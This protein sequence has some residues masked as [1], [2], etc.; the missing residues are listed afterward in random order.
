MCTW[1]QSN[2]AALS[3]LSSSLQCN[4]FKSTK[5]VNDYGQTHGKFILRTIEHLC[6][7]EHWALNE[8]ETEYQSTKSCLSQKCITNQR[9]MKCT[10]DETVN[11]F[12]TLWDIQAC[13][14]LS[15][16][17]F[18]S[19]LIWLSPISLDGF[20]HSFRQ[21]IPFKNQPTDKQESKT[22]TNP[23]CTRTQLQFLCLCVSL[24]ILS[25]IS[26]TRYMPKFSV[27]QNQVYK[28]LV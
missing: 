9:F 23:N 20:F 10:L 12:K 16:L 3:F 15:L 4:G 6:L 28:D 13:D 25:L 8:T 1:F 7:N 17:R 14:A 27:C 21:T 18:P 5:F 11:G 2:L 24:C 26:I 19:S 22:W